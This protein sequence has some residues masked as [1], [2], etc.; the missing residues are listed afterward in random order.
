MI[1]VIYSKDP[2]NGF[3]KN[4]QGVA[5]GRIARRRAGTWVQPQ[6]F[7]LYSTTCVQIT[8]HCF[9]VSIAVWW[10]DVSRTGREW[11]RHRED[12]VIPA[13]L[14][15]VTVAARFIVNNGIFGRISSI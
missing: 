8:Q 6:W 7:L 12:I 11:T 2:L 1:L 14:A 10:S 5:Q 9:E 15:V 3:S 13:Y 4:H